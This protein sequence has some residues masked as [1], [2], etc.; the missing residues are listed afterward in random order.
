MGTVV[1][2]KESDLIKGIQSAL[3]KDK[4]Y[5]NKGDN[6]LEFAR[7]LF[8]YEYKNFNKT[9]DIEFQRGIFED[10]IPKEK[11]IIKEY[12]ERFDNRL[13]TENEKGIGY[14]NE[15]FDFLIDNAVPMVEQTKPKVVPKKPVVP[16]NVN[17]VMQNLHKAF[18]GLGTDEDLAVKT[19]KMIN[20]KDVLT[21][22]DQTIA[23]TVGKKYPKIK[24]LAAW[25]NDEMSEVDPKQ[26]DAIW[27]HL[28]K[29]G[30]KGKESNKFLRVVG[31]GKEMVQKAWDWTK[32]SVIGK[33]FN[34][35]RDAANSGI[36]IAIQLIIDAVG[37]ETFGAA[38][39]I[40]AVVWGLIVEWDFVNLILGTP[41]WLNI[42]F[43]SL[44]LL[45]T[46]VMSSALA[47]YTK[48][49]KGAVFASIEKVF[50]WLSETA[51]GKL[52][53]RFLPAIEGGLGKAGSGLT[54]AAEWVGT[55]FKGLIG[56]E[57]ATLLKQG[58][59]KVKGWLAGFV[60]S[61]MKWFGKGEA[62]AAEKAVLGQVEKQAAKGLLD[63]TLEGIRSKLSN[64][65][66]NP[67]WLEGE[68]G[69]KFVEKG[70]KPAV[71]KNVEKYATGP[72][73]EY[74]VEKAAEMVD[75]KFG[76]I[77]GDMIR[78]AELAH[79]TGKE[80]K[81]LMKGLKSF[82]DDFDVKSLQKVA[83]GVKSASGEIAA[84]TNVGGKVAGQV[85]SGIRLGKE[86]DNYKYRKAGEKFFYAPKQDKNPQWKPVT[87]PKSIAYL[88]NQIYKDF[89]SPAGGI[90]STVAKN[91]SNLT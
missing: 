21:K 56:E 86:G 54:K 65:F 32:K 89:Y 59:S 1:Q 84:I 53:K 20:T 78:F 47:P 43:D 67:A 41:E 72:L 24:T 46:G 15:F 34:G 48:A 44:C 4:D 2:L 38:F 55:K 50:V 73:K 5:L 11:N 69:Q 90:A 31:K 26:Y 91:V 76:P 8:I 13:I 61:I 63:T 36:G 6:L 52:I 57:M 9:I 79:K 82:K 29:M 40:P 28:T 70:L 85:A 22:V 64:L 62:I 49:A 37:P 3:F 33:F 45:T 23:N 39:A 77:Y 42:I 35:L 19:I 68:L 12:R 81:G 88:K 87:S 71:T 58:A 83:K 66:K 51:F 7:K 75:Q 25:I 14:I 30:Y 27:G 16:A 74:G 80:S 10:I 60:E 18:D 17:V